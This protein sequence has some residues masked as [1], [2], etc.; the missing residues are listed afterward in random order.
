MSRF[1]RI[2]MNEGTSASQGHKSQVIRLDDPSYRANSDILDGMQFSA[3][4][5]IWTPLGVLKHH[6]EVF[7]G[8]P[9]QTPRYGTQADGIWTFK[10]KTFRNLGI[11]SDETE[12]THASDAGPIKPSR[13]LPF[14]VRFRS[15]VE[16]G[17]SHE[18][19]LAALT[20]L[21]TQSAE[22]SE[23][24]R[25]LSSNY[26]DFPDSFFYLQFTALPGIGR[27][28]AQRLYGAGFR[29]TSEIVG[30]DTSRLTAVPGLG[31]ATAAKIKAVCPTDGDGDA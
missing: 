1:K 24:W 28:L 19:K 25:K 17:I 6:G 5:Q 10:T 8:L 20:M 11:A 27:Q 4:L 12:F 3:A 26:G 31:R 22:F 14:L 18:D 2:V 13:Y 9:S 7:H 30:A 29:A 21:S 16:G 15:I 23:I